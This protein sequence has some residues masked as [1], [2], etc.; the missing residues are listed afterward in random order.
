LPN[1]EK[2]TIINTD[3]QIFPE[4]LPIHTYV[5]AFGEWGFQLAFMQ[6]NISNKLYPQNIPKNLKYFT[7]EVFQ[8]S[9]I[10]PPDISHRDTEINTMNKPIMV[11]A[12][13]SSWDSWE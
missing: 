1:N 3:A 8:Q 9:Q 2:V 6:K 7:Q 12:Y 11:E 4:T 13:R 5:P 10:F